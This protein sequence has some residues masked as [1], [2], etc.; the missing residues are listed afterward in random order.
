[1][2]LTVV[3]GAFACPLRS[4]VDP[5]K[6]LPLATVAFTLL[7]TSLP[8]TSPVQAGTGIQRCQSAD[9]TTIYTDTACSVLSAAS[10]PLPSDLLNRLAREAAKTSL[11]PAEYASAA[12]P[13]TLA[14]ARRSLTAGCARTPKQLSMDLRGSFALGDVNRLAESYHWVGLSQKQTKPIM[15]KLERL[16]LQPLDDAQYFDAPIGPDAIQLAD[17]GIG[18]G[19]AATGMMQLRFGGDL[20]QALDFDVARYAGCYFIKF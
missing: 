6:T 17:A 1:M 7:A 18:T 4:A 2:A 9:G 19:N 3:G 13:T 16:A 12:A 11:S 20:P 10:L 14:A 5:M 15:Q 8:L